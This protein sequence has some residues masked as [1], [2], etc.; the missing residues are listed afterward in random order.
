MLPALSAQKA[1]TCL[2]PELVAILT[3]PLGTPLAGIPLVRQSAQV[4]CPV[5]S[6]SVRDVL[7]SPT[8]GVDYGFP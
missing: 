4:S 5:K 1:V 6:I 3:T 2:F 8:A 7:N